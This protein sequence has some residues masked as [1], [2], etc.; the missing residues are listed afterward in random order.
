MS[1]C[2]RCDGSGEEPRGLQVNDGTM[3][4][5]LC[6]SAGS[7]S[8]VKATKELRKVADAAREIVKRSDLHKATFGCEILTEVGPLRA[9]LAAVHKEN[10]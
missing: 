2:L 3:T 8:V 9:A 6:F 1:D 10:K 5:P 4:C 7:V